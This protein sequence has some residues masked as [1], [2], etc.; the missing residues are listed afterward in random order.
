MTVRTDTAVTANAKHT[1]LPESTQRRILRGLL[2]RENANGRYLVD[3]EDLNADD[4]Y[5]THC[6][7]WWPEMRC[8]DDVALCLAYEAGAGKWHT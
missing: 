1:E 7:K 2:I 5:T 8:D 4:D 3:R 6:P